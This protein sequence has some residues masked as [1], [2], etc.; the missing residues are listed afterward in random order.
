MSENIE[1]KV[2]VMTGA[3]SALGEA[4]ARRLTQGGAKLVLGVR[5][6]D[7][8]QAAAARCYERVQARSNSLERQP[9]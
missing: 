7:R 1:G 8:L 6:V 9:L 2:I 5:R 3:S 4:A